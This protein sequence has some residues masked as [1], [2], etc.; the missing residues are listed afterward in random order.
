[1]KP[2]A[3]DAIPALEEALAKSPEH[4]RFE[5]RLALTRIRGRKR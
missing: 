3:L 2:P 1:M 4:R 5:F